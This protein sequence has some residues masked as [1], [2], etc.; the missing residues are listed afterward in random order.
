MAGTDRK[1]RS[2]K[3]DKHVRFESHEFNSEALKSLHPYGLSILLQ[4]R[5]RFNGKNNGDIHLGIK[6]AQK[7][8]GVGRRPVQRG[9]RELQEKGFAKV[10]SPGAFDCKIRHETT[11]ILTNQEFNNMPA[12]KEYMRWTPGKNFPVFIAYSDGV[13]N[14]P[15]GKKKRPEN[16]VHG[17]H[18]EHRKPLKETP[19]GVHSVPT[20]N[21]PLGGEFPGLVPYCQSLISKAVLVASPNKTQIWSNFV[22][23]AA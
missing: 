11:W 5:W 17:V 8:I 2:K 12:T 23:K 19:H 14:V 6:S 1:G 10:N 13:H 18:S 3:W 22:R 21:I 15:R 9:F 7:L 16:S 20:Y 4:L